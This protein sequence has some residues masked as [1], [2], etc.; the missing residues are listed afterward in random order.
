MHVAGIDHN[1]N[2]GCVMYYQIPANTAT[3]A[4]CSDES[5][6]ILRLYGRK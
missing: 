2:T 4:F 1:P 5:G 3:P 6:L